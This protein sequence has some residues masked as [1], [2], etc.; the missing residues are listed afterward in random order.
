MFPEQ[1]DN[2]NKT[3][4][5]EKMLRAAKEVVTRMVTELR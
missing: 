2:E 4:I 5:K 1:P 3:E